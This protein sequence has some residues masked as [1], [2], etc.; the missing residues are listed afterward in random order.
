MPGELPSDVSGNSATLEHFLGH[1]SY[2]LR[3]LIDCFPDLIFIKDRKSRIVVSNRAH[4]DVLGAAHLEDVAGKTDFD[5]FPESMAR[6]F[7][8]EEQALIASGRIL[9]VE[10]DVV[11]PRN[12]ELRWLHTT[13]VPLRDGNGSV[14]GLIGICRDITER[15]RTEQMLAQANR[16]MEQRV[17]ERTAELSRERLLLRT[18]V[19]NLPDYIFVKD[20]QSRFVL[21]NHACARQLGAQRPEDVLGKS[22]AD[23]VAPELA[24]QYLA[25]EQALMKSGQLVHKEEPTEHRQTGERRWSLTTKV[26]LTDENGNA[27]GLVGI[28]R[29]ITPIKEAE[30]KVEVLHR[31]L[32][33]ASRQAGMAEIATGVLHNVGNV[34]NSVNIS[35]ELMN[36]NLRRSKLDKLKKLADMLGEQKSDLMAFLA[37][38]N[39]AEQVSAYVQKLAETLGDERD[40]LQAEMSG[41]MQNIGHIKEIVA[42]QQNY[43]GNLGV[44]EKVE[45]AELVEDALKL[46][47]ALSDQNHVRVERQ[48]G[49]VPSLNQDRHKVLQILVN[50][51][52]NAK[53]AC[54]AGGGEQKRI[55]VRL[56]AVGA[57]RVRIEVADNGVGLPPENLGRIFSQGF[58]ARK[59]GHGFG[60][61]NSF[62]AAQ[63][64]GGCL[65]AQSDGLGRGA[66]FVLELPMSVRDKAGPGSR[67]ADQGEAA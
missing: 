51:F 46:S 52:S 59:D 28:G 8:T 57:D 13:K 7:F 45:I 66:T 58:T 55:Q 15:K 44:M 65:D 25:D 42:M 47:G 19:D 40:R 6:K 50:L 43:V 10:E 21:V 53:N 4:L 63:E 38:Q 32:V 41:L 16:D 31:R 22:D 49:S 26:P 64:L 5:L 14:A 3:V 37:A 24:A 9:D 12:G 48:F 23:F 62:L 36:D 11:D 60:L 17:A 29:D 2:W 27:G 18:L 56:G 35:A 20:A 39:R 1:H 54:D 34:L 61:H 67:Q 33:A 30:K